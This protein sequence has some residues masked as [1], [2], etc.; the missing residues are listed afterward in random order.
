MLQELSV[1]EQRYQAVLAVVEDGFSVTDVAAKVGVPPQTLPGRPGVPAVAW[2]VWRTARIARTR[3]RI[4]WTPGS[5]SGWWRCGV[6][7]VMVRN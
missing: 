4:R 1:S 3:V 5:R 6:S 2:R 7:T